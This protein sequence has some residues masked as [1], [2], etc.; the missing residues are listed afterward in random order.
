[1]QVMVAAFA[2]LLA[3]A[4][5][6]L[7]NHQWNPMAFV[8]EGT[9]FSLRD[10]SGT[11]GYDGQFVY[12][13][14][15]DPLGA[16]AYLDIPAHRYR[17]IV[18]P[19]LAWMLS[20]GGNVT[21]LP[22]VMLLINLLAAAISA[23]LLAQL[24]A[25]RWASPW[26]AL[27]LIFYIGMLFTVRA[28]LNEPL[29]LALALAGWLA[30][31]QRRFGVAIGLFAL[32]G[33]SKEVGL[34]IPAGL[35]AWELVSRNW[36]RAMLLAVG[37]AGPYL[38]WSF[39]LRAVFGSTGVVTTPILIP[40]LGIQYL[41]DPVGRLVVSLWVLFPAVAA[42]CWAT[43]DFFRHS[44]RPAQRYLCLLVLAHVALVATMPML[45]WEDPLAVLRVGLGLVAVIL[46]WLAAYHRR[47]LPY[48]IVLWVPSVVL[49]GLTPAMM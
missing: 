17:R 5:F 29:A 37:A 23:G 20:L 34:V 19:A 48:T 49:V 47:V 43:L 8:L 6:V 7:M 11:T 21:L 28:D 42:G 10:S 33:L 16:I 2:L 15:R 30:Y 38:L 41:T 14:A 39:I 25:K 18:Y 22:W 35:A 44:R 12:Y 26:Y 1:M 46:V 9:R 45:T 24:L 27:I 36:R 13:I 4:L 40:F 31:E 32:A 3:F